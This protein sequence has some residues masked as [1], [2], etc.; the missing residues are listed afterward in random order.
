MSD[1]INTNA[2]AASGTDAKRF[3]E[4]AVAW[5]VDPQKDPGLVNL[6]YL[7]KTDRGAF[8]GGKPYKTVQSCIAG[9]A[10]LLQDPK[11]FDIWY[12]TSL[13][14]KCKT[15]EKGGSF[16]ERNQENALYMKSLWIDIDVKPDNGYAT[17]EDAWQAFAEFYNQYKLPRPSCIVKSGGGLHI[18]WFLDKPATPAEW[19]PVATHLKALLIKSGLKCDAQITND[20]ARIMRVPET[21]NY[22][23]EGEKRPVE[24][25]YMEGPDYTLE[26]MWAVLQEHTPARPEAPKGSVP[27]PDAFKGVKPDPNDLVGVETGSEGIEREKIH[28]EVEPIF[29]GCGFLKNQLKTGGSGTSE[30]LWAAAILATTFLEGG[31]IIAHEIS[32]GYQGYD[33]DQTDEKFDK[34][35]EWARSKNGGWPTCAGIKEKGCKSCAACPHFG[36]IKS[37]L[38]LGLV[39]ARPDLEKISTQVKDGRLNPVAALMTL[40][41]QGADLQTLSTAMNQTYAV[42]K[43]G[44]QIIVASIIGNEVEFMKPEEF[45]KMFANLV[46]GRG[47]SNTQSDIV[48]KYWFGWKQ[49]RQYLGRGAVF[50]PGGPLDVPNDMLNIWRGFGVKAEQGDWSLMY[51]HIRDVICAG[52]EEH[53]HYLIRWMAYGVQHLDHPIGVTIA[54]RGDEGAGKGFL[55]R[56]YGKLFGRHF[57]HVAQ[58]EQLTG[59]FNATLAEACMVFLDEALWAGDHKGEQI[60]KALTTEDTFQLERKFCDPIPVK[61]YLRIVIASNNQWIVPVGT[62]GRRH[63]VLDVSDKYA[64]ENS[65]EH[66]DYWRPL[67]A[68]FGDRASDKGR[69]AMLYALLNM[70]LCDFN[71]RAVPKSAAKTEQ[72]LLTL[73]GTTS[74]LYHILQEGGIGNH[75]WDKTGLTISRDRAYGWYEDFIKDRHEWKP[76][77]RDLW[78]KTIRNVLGPC[79]TDVRSKEEGSRRRIRSF[80]FAPL[81]DCRS[82]FETHIGAPNIEW[83]PEDEPD[84]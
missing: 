60:L 62:G 14:K 69:A 9:L 43:Y 11:V 81:A 48:S 46:V 72:K 32:S 8:V 54:L 64:D 78:S 19:R 66:I 50:E 79:V 38:N 35:E 33:P 10:R 44:G 21:F 63:C 59:R 52:N 18:Y 84:D 17:V 12:C 3:L 28:L 2:A 57:K 29:R 82:R 1:L 23:V 53:F 37:P 40:R 77:I 26:Q 42:V 47:G 39:S 75:R 73:K 51:N 67:Q 70:D 45:H 20:A 34:K 25:S 4:R 6:H 56:N 31:R 76:E 65:P 61:N 36:K 71:I 74:W 68:Q 83:E 5:P 13:Q 58:G 80:R 7:Y 49:R 24:L 27:L 22:K 15:T 55:W 30:P 41:D 16:A